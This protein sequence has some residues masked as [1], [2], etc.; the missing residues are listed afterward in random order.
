MK[1]GDAAAAAEL[2]LAQVKWLPEILTEQALPIVNYFDP[3]DE[4]EDRDESDANDDDLENGDTG[5]DA[6]K[7]DDVEDDTDGVNGADSSDGTDP[8]AANTTDGNGE[9][10]PDGIVETPAWPFPTA[11]SAEAQQRMR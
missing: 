4:D 5:G 7:A 8:S 2:R 9:S 6:P 1:K 3:D 10:V 11:A